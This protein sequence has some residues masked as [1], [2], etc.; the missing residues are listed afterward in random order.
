MSNFT[1]NPTGQVTAGE[2]I[3]V[4][5]IT[6][7]HLVF[8]P[9]P[10]SFGLDIASF[11]FQV[12]DTGGQETSTDTYTMMI[13]VTNAND[14]PTGSNNTVTTLENMPYHFAVSDFGFNDTGDNGLTD[15]LS[16]VIITDITLNSVGGIRGINDTGTL[17]D[18]ATISDTNPNGA[19]TIG[20]AIPVADISHGDLVFTPTANSFGLDNASISFQVQDTGGGET[21]TDTYTMMINV[22]E[23][24][25]SGNSTFIYS[26]GSPQDTFTGLGTNNV[27]IINGDNGTDTIDLSSFPN[28]SSGT[29]S[30]TVN[31]VQSSITNVQSVTING[32]AGSDTIVAGLGS[33]TFIG[34][35][36]GNNS[37]DY[38]GLDVST[39]GTQ[40]LNV[41]TAST[42]LITVADNNNVVNDTLQNI[43]HIIGTALADTFDVSGYQS[44]L[45]LTGGGGNDTFVF[46]DDGVAHTITDFNPGSGSQI[47]LSAF[48]LGS[49]VNLSTT[50]DSSGNIVLLPGGGE[51]ID[52]IG[53]QH[54][55]DLHPGDFIF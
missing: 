5:D 41:T 16:N 36:G 48:G 14:A 27:L 39:W 20:Q 55:I 35:T 2:S 4:A 9:E 1:F 10:N 28:P 26:V 22:I 40:G 37:L 47:D 54:A 46:G 19:V 33:E 45:T 15:T 42:S 6:G 23:T 12:Q 18:S 7:G 24:G 11:S 31:G 50:T 34:G 38:S 32:G 52:L 44:P 29:G 53:V 17:T 25:T 30:F 51:S 3:P 8:T 49:L 43:G 21:S 13:N